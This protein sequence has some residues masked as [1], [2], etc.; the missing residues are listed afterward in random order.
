MSHGD[1]PWEYSMR[2]FHDDVLD[3]LTQLG[4]LRWAVPVANFSDLPNLS[5]NIFRCTNQT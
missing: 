3:V 5:L 1:V 4:L 2:I